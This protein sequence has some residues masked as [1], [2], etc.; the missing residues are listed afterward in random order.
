M[1]GVNLL[2]WREQRKEKQ[3][4]LFIFI[5]AGSFFAGLLI[6]IFTH[7]IIS[8]KIQQEQSTN[9][10]LQARIT[11]LDMQ[12]EQIKNLKT[13]KEE[14]SQRI[15]LIYKLQASRP[16]IVNAFDTL[17]KIMPSGLYIT[18]IK[19]KEDNLILKGNAESNARVSEL[20]VDAESSSYFTDA[21]LQQIKTAIDNSEYTRS[22]ILSLKLISNKN[23]TEK[24]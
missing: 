19:R 1:D 6:V 21:K 17:V 11:K 2:P 14:T 24:D 9:A 16:M 4:Q 7:T 22:F 23:Q 3:R 20:M 10:V 12:I 15:D 5:L 13:R 8:Q 18:S